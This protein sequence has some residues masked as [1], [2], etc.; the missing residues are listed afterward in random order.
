MIG[1]P[2]PDELRDHPT[3]PYRKGPD[4]AKGHK[5]GTDAQ[6][7]PNAPKILADYL[8]GMRVPALMKKYG[9][10][11]SA[12]NG[13]IWRAKRRA[14][15]LPISKPHGERGNIRGKRAHKTVRDDAQEQQLGKSISLPVVRWLGT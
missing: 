11:R 4:W 1:M 3:R 8:S 12:V 2:I 10:T 15:G 14:A 9:M 7:D 5:V 6:M 13:A